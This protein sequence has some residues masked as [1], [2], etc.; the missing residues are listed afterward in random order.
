MRLTDV[1]SGHD[2]L[3]PQRLIQRQDAQQ[4]RRQECMGD[5]LLQ[6]ADQLQRITPLVFIRHHQFGATEPGG[7]NVDD[8]RVETQRRELQHPA[9]CV[10]A[11]MLGIPGGEVAEIALAEQYAFRLPGGARRVQRHAGRILIG[12][13]V[14]MC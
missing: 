13:N 11:H 14:C 10:Q 1:A 4:R 8:R 5:A 6:H 2:M 3:K 9:V 12:S 7:K